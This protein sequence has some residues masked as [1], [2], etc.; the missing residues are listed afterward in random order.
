MRQLFEFVKVASGEP[1]PFETGTFYSHFDETPKEFWMSRIV[2]G[3]V[4]HKDHYI[5]RPAESPDAGRE[6]FIEKVGDFLSGKHKGEYYS[7]NDFMRSHWPAPAPV[8][9]EEIEQWAN[10][11]YPVEGINVRSTQYANID[12][13]MVALATF[14][15]LQGKAITPADPGSQVEAG[16]FEE[17]ASQNGWSYHG[18]N[19]MWYSS[20]TH[21]GATTADLITLYKQSL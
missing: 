13:R 8:T 2:K 4:H 20:R 5:L 1:F 12:K 3:S 11:Q 17:W 6:D 19:A 10:Y 9:R 21:E 15:Y 16:K 18:A 14:D 7:L